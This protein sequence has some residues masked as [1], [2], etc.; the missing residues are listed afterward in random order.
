[1]SIEIYE[2]IMVMHITDT[3]IEE[4]IRERRKIT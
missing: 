4:S 1:M 2:Q 3:A